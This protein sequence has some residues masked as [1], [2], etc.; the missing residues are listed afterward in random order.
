MLN[1][2]DRIISKTRS[3]W[4]NTHKYNIR[5]SSTVKEAIEIYKENGNTLW[6]DAIMK[7]IKLYDLHSKS[8]RNASKIYQS[9]SKKSSVT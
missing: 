3:F 4:V 2:R 1:K 5:V 8:G 7:E 6:W 9:Y